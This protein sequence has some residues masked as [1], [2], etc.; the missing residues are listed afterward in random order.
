MNTTTTA[1]TRRF[2]RAALTAGAVAMLTAACASEPTESTG[3]D[4][5]DASSV[6]EA[7]ATSDAQ[8]GP[9]DEP[10]VESVAGGSADEIATEPADEPYDPAATPLEF[11]D[12][13]DGFD[14]AMFP[15]PLDYDDPTGATVDIHI[16]RQQAGGERVGTLFVNPGGPGFGAE[17]MVRG[18]GRFGPP[19]VTEAFDLIGI[20]PRGDGPERCNR[21][22]T[23]TTRPTRGDALVRPDRS[24]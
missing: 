15:V 17:D 5:G 12:C 7:S 3:S 8:I 18:I 6:D 1:T 9:D 23:P 21:P 14:C 22:A 13:G 16:T 10:D 24:R 2:G 11:E 19:P 4:V 20:D